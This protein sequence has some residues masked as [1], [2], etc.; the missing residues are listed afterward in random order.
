MEANR[1][2]I[3]VVV[4]IYNTE[5]YL[6]KCICSIMAQSYENL[7]IILVDDGST[8]KS[9]D[10]C[11]CYAG[12]D[13]RI[14]VH[15]TE[16]K[17]LVAARKLGLEKAKG[18]YIGFVDGDDYIAPNMFQELLQN[19]LLSGAD[20]V[21]SGFVQEMNER[22]TVVC[23]FEEVVVHTINKS[24][25]QDFLCKYFF[26]PIGTFIYPSI[27][28]K[29]FKADFIKKCYC[30]LPD[31]Q[32]YGEDLLCLIRCIL[33]SNCISLYPK[34]M[35]NYVVK[36]RSLSQLESGERMLKAVSLWNYMVDTLTEYG[37]PEPVV[38]DAKIYIRNDMLGALEA[39]GKH[40]FHI[41]RYC[42][43]QMQAILGKRIVLYG[44][45]KVGQDY[46][47][48]ICKYKDCTIVAWVD[49]NWQNYQFDYC[50]IVEIEKI[51]TLSYDVIL[52][53]VNNAETAQQIKNDLMEKG[54][55]KEKIY[56]G[57]S[58]LYF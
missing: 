57:K 21:H 13:E 14:E 25:C 4:P 48:Q 18:Q 2:N 32:Q 43:P 1:N 20:F 58:E 23:S 38:E 50:E 34:A 44:A 3:S 37:C 40:G 11:D 29:L 55:P 7:Q 39:M 22:Q 26:N 28:S 19:A 16:N 6:E 24:G 12:K 30:R 45:G 35:Y 54:I 8:D 53:A 51:H 33:E 49:I 15:H 47:A 31:G 27:W 41:P 56:W 36:E 46:Y 42:F 17:G 9:G 5:A 52:I 10:I